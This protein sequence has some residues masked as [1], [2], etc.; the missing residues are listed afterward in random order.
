MTKKQLLLY[1][2]FYAFA[3]A[4]AYAVVQLINYVIAGHPNSHVS[5]FMLYVYTLAALIPL[6]FMLNRK[7]QQSYHLL[8]H[9]AIVFLIQ[10]LPHLSAPP[11]YIVFEY[12]FYIFLCLYFF[13]RRFS[14]EGVKVRD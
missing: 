5:D 9:L 6:E 1:F 2:I 12:V 3:I 11:A 8:L 7:W 10:L 4:L 13:V 14:K